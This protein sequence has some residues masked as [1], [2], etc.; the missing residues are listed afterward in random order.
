V[1]VAFGIW[2]PT[3]VLPAGFWDRFGREE[4][5]AM[6]AHELAHLAARDPLWQLLAELACALEWWHPAVWWMRGRLRAASETAADEASLLV[7]GG[8]DALA[9]C[10]VALGR[11]LV[12]P[13]RLGWLSFQGNGF[14]SGLGR[15]VERLLSL[16]AGAAHVPA[17]AGLKAARMVLP[18]VLVVVSVLSTAWARPQAFFSEGET[19]MSVWRSSW[20]HSL[21]AIVVTA[22]WGSASQAPAQ[23]IPK[24]PEH[25][26]AAV[27]K[28]GPEVRHEIRAEEIRVIEAKPSGQPH[29]IAVQAT[30]QLDPRA[31]ELHQRRKELEERTRD[32]AARL[33]S[34]KPGQD[35][36]AQELKEKIEA[37]RREIEEVTRQIERAEPGAIGPEV[38]DLLMKRAQLERKAREIEAKAR[39]RPDS[40][41]ARELREAL[42]KTH[43]EIAEITERLP[44]QMRG[45]K[46]A[47]GEKGRVMAFGGAGGGGMAV[48]GPPPIPPEERER[49][50]KHLKIAV[51]NLHA[52]GLPDQAE[53]LAREGEAILQG[54][55]VPGMMPPGPPMGMPGAP[56]MPGM[57]PGGPVPP[58]APGMGPPPPQPP[59]PPEAMLR[60]L[61]EQIRAL[62]RQIDE[63]RQ[64]VRPR[65]EPRPRGEEPRLRDE[66]R[67]RDQ[68]R[69]REERRPR[70]ELPRPDQP[71]PREK[72]RPRE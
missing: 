39:Q 9:G 44:P 34:L 46:I 4:Q 62:Q 1:P 14:R 30:A 33:R 49:R 3:I 6:L 37:T 64:Q 10:L 63:L 29:V 12:C 7:P 65:E 50:M 42:E 35:R 48:G 51:E 2:R 72:D 18:V 70:D 58:G 26:P 69:P 20:R 32:L 56:G 24:P 53:R 59:G 71:K 54:R 38:R 57:M 68:A 43:R 61:S 40:P 11:R 45:M 19:T 55:P 27:H 15:R 47:L 66:A 60:E 5:E 8:P 41:E 67:P 22:F 31:R 28:E 16:K 23:E 21:A 36:E 52:A 13:R 17:R 25:K